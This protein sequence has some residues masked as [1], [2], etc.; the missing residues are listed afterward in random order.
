MKLEPI[1]NMDGSAW[2]R[3]MARQESESPD[4]PLPHFRGPE[5]EFEPDDWDE[6][7]S[8]FHRRQ[9]G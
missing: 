2:L 6:S 7:L 4:A 5:I 1:S 8:I 9:A 3:E